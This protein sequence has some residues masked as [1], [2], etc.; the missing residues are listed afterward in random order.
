MIRVP[1]TSAIHA[2]EQRNVVRQCICG[3]SGV[4]TRSSKPP[5]QQ[6]EMRSQVPARWGDVEGPTGPA[7]HGVTARESTGDVGA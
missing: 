1:Q 4:S 5:Q 2:M 3:A 7:V 6:I